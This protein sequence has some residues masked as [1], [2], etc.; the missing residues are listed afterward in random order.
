MPFWTAGRDY[1]ARRREQLVTG[2][3]APDCPECPAKA[4]Q[5]CDPVP[6][7]LVRVDRNP[8]HAVHSARIVAAAESGH[9]RR[10]LL[11]AQFAGGQLP[12]GLTARKTRNAR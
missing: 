11:V 3:L 12:S 4:G 1:R 5:W 10:D 8:P 6:P 2:L 7:E 9:V